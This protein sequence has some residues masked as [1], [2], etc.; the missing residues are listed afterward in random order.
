MGELIESDEEL[1]AADSEINAKR[2]V[3]MSDEEGEEEEEQDNE[4][5]YDSDERSLMDSD[6]ER[7][8]MRK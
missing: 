7:G 3:E 4:F 2:E 5:D 6:D 1:N 8:A